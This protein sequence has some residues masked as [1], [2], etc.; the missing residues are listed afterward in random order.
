MLEIHVGDIFKSH[1]TKYV[2]PTFHIATFVDFEHKSV[3]FNT[4]YLN[5]KSWEDS[6]SRDFDWIERALKDK[7][8]ETSSEAEW[9][10]ILLSTT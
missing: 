7:V 6:L 10:R 5:K 4:Y 9:A 3:H 8:W 1:P 2:L